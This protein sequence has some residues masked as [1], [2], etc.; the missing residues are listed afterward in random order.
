MSVEFDGVEHC[1]GGNV[2]TLIPNQEL[3]FESQWDDGPFV[4][5]VPTFWTIRLSPLYSATHV[6]LFHHGF[7]RLGEA[8]AENLEGYEQGWDNKHLI[9]LRRIV[10]SGAAES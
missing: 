3:S 10:E 6:E 9:A 4:W 8:A 2:L 5:S 7:E 1:Y